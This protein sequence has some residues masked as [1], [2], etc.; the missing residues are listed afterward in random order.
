MKP[1]GARKPMLLLLG[2]ASVLAMAIVLGLVPRLGRR[3]EL[4]A[5]AS[6]LANERPTVV[7]T[8]AKVP[9]STLSTSLP[10][11]VQALEETT[12]FA[13]TNGYVKRWLRDIGDTVKPGELLAEIDTPELDQELG[14]A[15]ATLNQARAGVAQAKANAGLAQTVA[16]RYEQ[17]AAAGVATQ[18]DLEEKRAALAVATANVQAAEASVQNGLSNEGRL[19]QTKGFARLLAPFGGI[20]TARMTETGALVMAGNGQGQAL[21]RVANVDTVRVFLHAPQAIAPG[22]REGQA[23]QLTVTGYP[24][25]SFEGKVTRTSRAIDEASRTMLTE[26]QVQNQDHSL[27]PGMYGQV[28]FA[29]SRVESTVLFP[30]SALVFS[31]QGTQLAVVDND[32]RV[33]LIKIHVEADYGTEIGVSAHD[34]SGN[35]RV[36]VNPS[37]KVVDG[38]YVTVAAAAPTGS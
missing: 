17:L 20:V 8:T 1:T 23:A 19:Q 4:R 9:S 5:E 28:T 22:V 24:G 26:V 21:F 14:Q 15:L 12:I 32:N 31:A 36:V 37:E 18:Q 30:A 25:R 7:L 33:H 2:L 3:A 16:K 6:R 34:L 27:L 29:A 35:E 11:T 38:A 10:C 13:R